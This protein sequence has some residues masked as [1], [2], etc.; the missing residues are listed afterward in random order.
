[1]LNKAH[2]LHWNDWHRTRPWQRDSNL[3]VKRLGYSLQ[4]MYYQWKICRIHGNY[5]QYKI[6]RIHRNYPEKCA[7]SYNSAKS[8]ETTLTAKFGEPME[9]ITSVKSAEPVKTTISE[10]FAESVKNTYQCK[11]YRIHENYYECKICRIHGN[12]YQWKFCS[13]WELIPVEKLQNP[14]KPLPVEMQ[15]KKSVHLLVYT[16]MATSKIMFAT[17][18]FHAKIWLS[19]RTLQEHCKMHHVCKNDKL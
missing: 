4:D 14:W 19:T 9:T 16:T 2:P 10:K 18:K 1:M 11:I 7:E 17:T 12:Y 6:C 15:Q 13:P 8:M 5:Y 3:V